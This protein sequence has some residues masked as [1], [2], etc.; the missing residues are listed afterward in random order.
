MNSLR[1]LSSINMVSAFKMIE[2]GWSK[3][4]KSLPQPENLNCIPCAHVTSQ[5]SW[6]R[7]CNPSTEELE[8]GDSGAH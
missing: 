2:F 7:A 1:Y 5:A 6:R 8:E 3:T 4:M